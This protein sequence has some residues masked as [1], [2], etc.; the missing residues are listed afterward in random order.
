MTL[1]K[2]LSP[3]RT[4]VLEH[5][6][7]RITPPNALN[8]PFE[9]KPLFDKTI[10]PAD[11]W[12]LLSKSPIDI[13]A[14]V[15]RAYDGLPP[16]QKRVISQEQFFAFMQAAVNTPE[17]SELVALALG[18]IVDVLNA[19]T[20][21]IQEGLH[22]AAGRLIGILSLS[23]IADN[24]LMWSHYAG[25][26]RGFVLGLDENHEFFNRPRSDQDEFYRLRKV[27]Y[28]PRGKLNAI[29]G[30]TGDD[31]L[32]TKGDDWSY[33]REW[34]FLAPVA[35]ADEQIE[36]NGETIHLFELPRSCVRSVILGT[37][38]QLSLRREIHRILQQPGYEGVKRGAMTISEDTG[39]LQLEW[40]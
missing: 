3:P 18:Q 16:A 25:S 14:E 23:E 1:F 19:C 11:A 12:A 9:L 4:D 29:F 17:G 24:E 32:V 28:R 31:L 7:I 35:D 6:L 37:E 8:D 30:V 40:A 22:D 2:Y 26:H 27:L 36:A 33:E 13:T 21:A 34:R 38:T 20:R 5:N 15:Q 39:R 10:E